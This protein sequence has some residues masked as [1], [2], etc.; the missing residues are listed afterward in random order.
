M[1][2]YVL[3][4]LQ[5]TLYDQVLDNGLKVVLHPRPEMEKTYAIF[6][7]RYGSIDQTFTP[8][9]QKDFVTVPDGIA[10]FLEHKLFEKKDRD[11]FMDFTRQGASANAFTSFSRTAYLFSSTQN[12]KENVETL[13][14]FVQ[15]PYFSEETVEKEKGIIA[16][17]INMYD[18]EPGWRLFFGTIQSLFSKHPVRIDIAGTVDSIQNITK[19]DLYTCYHTFYHPANMILF[20]TG[21]FNPEEMFKI[22]EH[23]QRQKTFSPFEGIRRYFPVEPDE[24]LR[25]VNQIHMPVSRPKCMVGLKEAPSRLT[26]NHLMT[27]RFVNAMIFDY[28]FSKSGEFYENLYEEG[29]IEDDFDYE[30]H[31]EDGF[32]F[33][34]IGGS[35][36]DP[37][38]LHQTV[39]KMLLKLTDRGI[40]DEEFSR[41]KKK[42]IGSV[43]RSLNSLE[44]TANQ[45]IYYHHN[46]LNYFDV[47]PELQ[48]LNLD[49]FRSYVE[50]WISEDRINAC[51]IL[52]KKQE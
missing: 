23:N 5:E 26:K 28:F 16:Q 46:D 25:D 24:A 44:S 37:E 12:V 49:T 1:N 41:M 20:V 7:T 51:Y 47:L 48:N 32:G 35:T 22:I 2:E 36:S 39:T 14:D 30:M 3:E 31:M 13:L 10:H 19:D 6:A 4:Q 43:L 52:P 27:A 40:S 21:P 18:D 29:L 42:Q 33:S 11:V 34:V 38:K 8:I 45:Y 50:S 17:E 9:G 15:E